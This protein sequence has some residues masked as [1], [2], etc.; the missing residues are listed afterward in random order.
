VD[1]HSASDI[2]FYDLNGHASL[3]GLVST[4]AFSFSLSLLPCAV[5]ETFDWIH[6]ELAWFLLLVLSLLSLRGLT[7]NYFMADAESSGTIDAADAP[8]C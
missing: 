4:I 2:I 8:F 5:I 1:W 3:P 6:V 7:E